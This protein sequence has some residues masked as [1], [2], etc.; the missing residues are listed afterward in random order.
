MALLLPS[1]ACQRKGENV[2]KS[3]Y[4]FSNPNLPNQVQLTHLRIE[5]WRYILVFWFKSVLLK[6]IF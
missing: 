3:R 5:L 4:D 6:L 2:L 1:V